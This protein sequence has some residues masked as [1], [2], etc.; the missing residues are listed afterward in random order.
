MAKPLF[1]FGF[2]EKRVAKKILIVDDEKIARDRMLR[3][4]K[5]YPEKIEIL[6]ATNGPEALTSIQENNPNVI[7]LD[8]QMPE[9]TGFDVLYQIEERNFQVVFQTAFDEFAIQ[10]FEVNACDYLLKPYTEEKMHSALKKALAA[11]DQHTKLRKLEE[12]LKKSDNFLKTLIT[13]KGTQTKIIDLEEITYFKSE[14]HYTF[15]VTQNNEF[16]IDLSLNSLEEKL[17]PEAFIR[18]HRNCIVRWSLIDSIG[19]TENSMLRLKNGVELP[20]SREN[21]K[22]LLQKMKAK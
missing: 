4:L 14:D 20:V 21:R 19:S 18:S 17:N 8:I 5:T 7:F 10:A 22:K 3:F 6:Q 13:K 16:I 9:V 11:H 15:A 12:H 1:T 2:R